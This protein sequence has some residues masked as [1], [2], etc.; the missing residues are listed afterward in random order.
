LFTRCGGEAV[1]TAAAIRTD[2]SLDDVA[3]AEWEAL[4]SRRIFFG[5]QSVGRNI[6]DGVRAV[7][8]ERPGIGVR[9]V[10]TEDPASVEGAAFIHASIGENRKPA[11]K[12]AAFVK[13]IEKGLG[14]NPIAM[15]K[16][17]YVDVDIETDVRQLFDAYAAQ[18]R[19]IEAKHPEVTL[20]HITLPLKTTRT[21]ATEL[22]A[23][24]LGRTTE[25]DVNIKRNRFNE[26]MRA[27][28]S[29]RS[30]LFDLA[31]LGSTRADGSRSYARRRGDNVSMLAPEWTY[32][33]GHLNEAGRRNVAER[34]L[35]MLA[36]LAASQSSVEAPDAAASDTPATPH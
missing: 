13:A 3:P 34:F 22:V 16:Y 25:L 33:D 12:A 26:L 36:D 31:E 1:G 23:G 32:D 20:V 19:A 35:V 10:P 4:A 14:P 24:L 7:L 5:H 11:T 29:G 21:G 6:M 27:E 2:R 30:P 18:S 9:V 17:C 28:Y 8:A 15:Y